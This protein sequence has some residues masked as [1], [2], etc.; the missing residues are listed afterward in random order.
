[1]HSADA[2]ISKLAWPF[3]VD[4]HLGQSGNTYDGKL[5]CRPYCGDRLTACAS[6]ERQVLQ[7]SPKHLPFFDGRYR[8]IA[9]VIYGRVL[10]CVKAWIVK[11]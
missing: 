10:Q 7:G 1:M 5:R 2:C 11:E 4:G 6:V 9:S 3:R 8:D